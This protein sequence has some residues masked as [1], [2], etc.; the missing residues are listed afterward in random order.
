[1]GLLNKAELD[2]RIRKGELIRNPRLRSDG[3]PDLQP[4]SYDL[5]AGRAVWK[6]LNSTSKAAGTQIV[7][8]LYEPSYPHGRQAHVSLQPGQMMS[9]ITHEE[10]IMPEELC[11]TVY[12]KNSLALNGIFA[13]NS[14]HVDPGFSGPIVIRLINLRSTPWTFTLG[15]RIFTITFQTVDFK[16]GDTYDVRPAIDADETLRRVRGFA[17]V[18]LSNALFDLYAQNIEDRLS[19]FRVETINTLRDQLRG[20]FLTQNQFGGAL[21]SWA[22][23]YLIVIAALFGFLGLLVGILADWPA[24]LEWLRGLG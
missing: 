10:V 2:R 24:V 4:A 16:P 19:S 13:F 18:A 14:G 9:V 15:D 7:E 11:G 12:S 6:E 23:H 1:M 8:E 22:K 21:W 20:E 3:S 5:T 17:D